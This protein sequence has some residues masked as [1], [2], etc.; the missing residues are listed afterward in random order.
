MGTVQI[1]NSPRATRRVEKPQEP[2]LRRIHLD[3]RKLRLF[4]GIALLIGAF[5]LLLWWR[6]VFTPPDSE[7]GLIRRL[8]LTFKE[9]VS[10]HDWPGVAE[11]CDMTPQRAEQW[12]KSVQVGPANAIV[13]DDVQFPVGFAVPTD[14]QS[15]ELQVTVFAH[16]QAGP[17]SF[18]DSRPRTGIVNYVRVNGKWRV[19]IEKSAAAFGVPIPPKR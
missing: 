15:Y 9:R 8:T 5:F 2:M 6:G 18:T 7:E 1:L 3:S 10:A 12:I 17:F 16:G 14:A 4:G 19:D 13:V 11:L